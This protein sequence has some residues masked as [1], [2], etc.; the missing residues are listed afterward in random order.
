MKQ[1]GKKVNNI[2]KMKHQNAY[3]RIKMLQKIKVDNI[4]INSHYPEANRNQRI[5]ES[6]YK[7]KNSNLKKTNRD[8]FQGDLVSSLYLSTC[9]DFTTA[10]LRH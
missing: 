7:R 4:K 1:S 10:K 9:V 2:Q 3:K 5:P 8:K 6:V